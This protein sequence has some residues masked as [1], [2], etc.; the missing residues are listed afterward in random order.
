MSLSDEHL[1]TA[2]RVMLSVLKRPEFKGKVGLIVVA[3]STDGETGIC[4]PPN[5]KVVE[6]LE[7]ALRRHK[8]IKEN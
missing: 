3:Y 6:I 4:S 7:V 1:K 8:E 2:A 5:A